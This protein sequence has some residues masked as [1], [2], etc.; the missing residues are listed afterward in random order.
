MAEMKM[1]FSSQWRN[2]DHKFNFLLEDQQ[3][4]YLISYEIRVVDRHFFEL[5][6]RED[7]HEQWAPEVI[8]IFRSGVPSKNTDEIGMSDQK[9]GISAS[10][11]RILLQIYEV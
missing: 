5:L 9:K 4:I 10:F 11:L 3:F 7:Q 6:D 1:S 2:S 8:S